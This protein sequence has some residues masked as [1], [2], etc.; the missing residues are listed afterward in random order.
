MQNQTTS[1][2]KFL[3]IHQNLFSTSIVTELQLCI[4]G[5]SD[6]PHILLPHRVCPCDFSGMF[7]NEIWAEVMPLLSLFHKSPCLPPLP[8]TPWPCAPCP[9]LWAGMTS[10]KVNVVAICGRWPNCLHVSSCLVVGQFVPLH[11]PLC[12]L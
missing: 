12:L 6:I 5:C 3:A 1:W 8:S 2:Q 9:F 10:N 11:S 4:Y 7:F